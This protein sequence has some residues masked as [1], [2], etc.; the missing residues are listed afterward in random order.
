MNLPMQAASVDREERM[1]EAMDAGI[2]P[3][4]FGLSW[5]DIKNGISTVAPYAMNAAKAFL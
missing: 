3:A 1:G 2:D 4:L 5:D